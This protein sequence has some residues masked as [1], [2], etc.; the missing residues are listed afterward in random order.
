MFNHK[1]KGQKFGNVIE[2][3]WYSNMLSGASTHNRNIFANFTQW[4][5]EMIVGSG[6]AIIKGD[7]LMPM[8]MLAGSLSGFKKGLNAAVYTQTTGV[9]LDRAD[10]T[11]VLPFLEWWRYDTGNKFVNKFILWNL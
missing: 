3:I 9:R 1:V 10:K 4:I 8:K 5:S 7:L 6:K 2:A 11:E